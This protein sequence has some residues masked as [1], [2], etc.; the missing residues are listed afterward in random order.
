MNSFEY[1]SHVTILMRLGDRMRDV[2][3]GQA[4]AVFYLPSPELFFCNYP[5]HAKMASQ[6]GMRGFHISNDELL[7]GFFLQTYSKIGS[8]H[9]HFHTKTQELIKHFSLAPDLFFEE[10]EKAEADMATE[11]AMLPKFY[12]RTVEA[13]K[14]RMHSDFQERDAEIHLY[15]Y[16][17]D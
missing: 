13:G 6:V 5:N 10:V 9:L 17:P 1:L 12:P 8:L 7:A 16:D 2:R 15:D 11:V 3:D 14:A 4:L